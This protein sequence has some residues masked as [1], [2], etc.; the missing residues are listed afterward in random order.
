MQIELFPKVRRVP[1]DKLLVYAGLPQGFGIFGAPATGRELGLPMN[2]KVDVYL[3][4][5]NREQAGLGIPLPAGRMRVSQLDAKDDTLEFIG[6]D[7]IDHTPKDEKVLVQLGSAFDVVGE[8]RQVEFQIDNDARRMEE[9]IEIKVR[10]HKDEPV[11][12]LVRETMYRWSQNDVFESNTRYE[13][14]DARTVNFPV[15]IAK[16]GEAVVRYRV[17]YRW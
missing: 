9:T 6:E 16:D 14:E 7:V 4:F 8:R 1:A 5:D 10:N 12:V 11:D 17:R 13:R 2:T 15:T 3:R